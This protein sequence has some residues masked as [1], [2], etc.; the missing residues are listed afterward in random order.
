M[1]KQPLYK[2]P[3]KE[4]EE[5]EFEVNRIFGSRKVKGKVEYKVLWMDK[6]VTWEPLDN[7]QNCLECVDD[8][9]KRRYQ[10]TL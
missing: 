2:Q 7:L 8:F 9:K 4:E 3:C 6:S 1:P 5:E 10:G